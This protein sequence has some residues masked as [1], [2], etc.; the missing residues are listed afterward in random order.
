MSDGKTGWG[1]TVLGWFVVRDNE[2]DAGPAP[3]DVVTPT[4]AIEPVGDMPDHD[5]SRGRADAG[6]ASQGAHFGTG[7]Q[8]RRHHRRRRRGN[9][10]GEDGRQ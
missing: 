2:A 3:T 9:C 8:G 6:S 10:L 4:A 5:W 7:R 1:N